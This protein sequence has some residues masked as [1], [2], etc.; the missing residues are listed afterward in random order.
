MTAAPYCGGAFVSDVTPMIEVAV[1]PVV[2]AM[3][4]VAEPKTATEE[5]SLIVCAGPVAE[6]VGT[7]LVPGDGAFVGTGVG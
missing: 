6:A 3:P 4:V 5:A 7:G 2:S 1:G